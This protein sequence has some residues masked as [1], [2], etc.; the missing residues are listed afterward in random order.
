MPKVLRRFEIGDKVEV[1]DEHIAGTVEKIEGPTVTITTSDGFSL[2]FEARQVVKVAG[3]LRVTDF[4][5]AQGK[6]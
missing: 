2:A 5:I 6:V 1:V 3:T 4:D